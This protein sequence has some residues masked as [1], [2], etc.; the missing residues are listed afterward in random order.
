MK[1]IIKLISATIALLLIC[2]VLF[3]CD[4][5]SPEQNTSDTEAQSA[6][7]N[8]GTES[9]SETEYVPTIEKKDY[10]AEFFL[11]I[12]EAD[13]PI[14]YHWVEEGNNDAMSESIY[15]RQINIY[16]HLGVDIIG[17]PAGSHEGHA[18]EFMTAIK[19]KDGSV[20]TLVS[21]AYLGIPGYI[22]GGY[23]RDFESVPEIDLGADYW[24]YDFME[25]LSLDGSMYIGYS[26]FNIP[27]IYVISF[28]KD[29]M[30]K[31][32]GEDENWIYKT[33]TD[34]KWTLDEM[35]ALANLVSIDTTGDGKTQDDVY[36]IT[37]HQ[38]IPF[39]CFME[40]SNIQ[41]VDL[42]EAGTPVVSVYTS[43]NASKTVTLI[44]KLSELAKS[45]SS[46]FWYCTD[47]T[48][49]ISIT[50]GRTLMMLQQSF[51]LIGNLNY[52]L[53][54]GVLPYPMYDEAQKDVGYRTQNWGGT[55]VI[56]SYL[57]SP[58]MVGETL[59]LLAFYSKDVTVTFYEKLLGKQV[60]DAPNDS[61]ML[62]I[63]WDSVCSDIGLTYSNITFELDK[64]LYMLP[65]MTYEFGTAEPASFI[66]SYENSANKSLSKFMKTISLKK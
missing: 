50:S 35:I 34:Y 63:I 31:Y 49:Q 59:E 66:K 42:N 65:Q 19:N 32:T 2:S 36:G 54:F 44:D 60:A 5:T 61:A 6:S 57:E 9:D 4:T 11:S 27:K 48:P 47:P 7:A 45:A 20:D 58:E 38:W 18:A 24:N 26:D 17:F 8:I 40:A 30:A 33:V 29:M 46:W 22:S 10:G 23:L 55:L 53:N 39:S 56:P 51:G 28:N 3:A 43:I 12:Y 16:E 64:N 1:H 13:N 14:N 25:S 52:E 21:H 62:D 37:G 15:N 41:L